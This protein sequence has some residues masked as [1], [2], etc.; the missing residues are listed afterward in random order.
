MTAAEMVN[1]YLQ[2][3]KM[4]EIP[5]KKTLGNLL[6]K[7]DEENA[8]YVFTRLKADTDAFI[9]DKMSS[10][11]MS[12]TKVLRCLRQQYAVHHLDDLP[13][14]VSGCTSR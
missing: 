14:T 2:F 12:L 5:S 7:L 13:A 3:E 10:E 11:M 6:E 9:S 8:E 1:N 4:P